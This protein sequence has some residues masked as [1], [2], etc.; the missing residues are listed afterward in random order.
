MVGK[1][2]HEEIE[3]FNEEVGIFEEDQCP[4]VAENANY[5]KGFLPGLIFQG[6][7]PQPKQVINA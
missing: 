1:R 4:D 2:D 5:V 7:Q 6:I 3:T